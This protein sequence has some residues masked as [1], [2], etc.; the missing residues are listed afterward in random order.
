MDSW[1]Y[2]LHL[3]HDPR[4]PRVARSTTRAVLGLY[5]PADLIDSAALLVSELVTNAVQHT[6]GPSQLRLRGGVRRL[7]VA[8]WDT[9]PVVPPVFRGPPNLPR[10]GWTRCP[11][12]SVG[13]AEAVLR[14]E[15]VADRGRGLEIVRSLAA[16][17]GAYVLGDELYGTSGKLLWVEL[18]RGRD[19]FAI[20]A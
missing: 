7:R 5:G 6:E 16:N 19:G 20:A 8:V 15:S 3:P 10:P 2:S 11:G 14:G 12:G 13:S 18:P 9:D 17:W 1:A 4:A